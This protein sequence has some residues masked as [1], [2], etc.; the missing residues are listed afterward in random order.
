MTAKKPIPIS[1]K[2][3][4]EVMAQTT[5]KRPKMEQTPPNPS[6]VLPRGNPERPLTSR[7]ANLLL[8]FMSTEPSK[9]AHS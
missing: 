3:T 4:C 5:S 2:N 1:Y 9:I 8:S 7:K 6:N